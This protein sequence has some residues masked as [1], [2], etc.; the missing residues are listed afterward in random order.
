MHNEA[1][2]FSCLVFIAFSV[3]HEQLV[4]LD[5]QNKNASYIS[6][7]FFTIIIPPVYAVYRGYIVFA[8]YTHG[9]RSI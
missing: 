9:I 2:W 4:A 6:G 1:H 3:L 7:N 5:Q 8:F